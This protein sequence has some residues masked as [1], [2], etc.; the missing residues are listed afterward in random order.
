MK[1]RELS[2]IL[3]VP[4]QFPFSLSIITSPYLL[5]HEKLFHISNSCKTKA[6]FS[7]RFAHLIPCNQIHSLLLLNPSPKKGSLNFFNSLYKLKRDS[8]KTDSIER[9]TLKS[10]FQKLDL[11]HL[12]EQRAFPS[13]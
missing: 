7:Y 9:D 2:V 11:S 3:I 5:S 10:R 6:S 8:K 1:G 13:S 12:A 4:Y